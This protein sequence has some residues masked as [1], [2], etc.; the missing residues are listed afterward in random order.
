MVEFIVDLLSQGGIVYTPR[1]N[2]LPQLWTEL[3]IDAVDD[4]WGR[5]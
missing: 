4:L 5:G 3:H 2:P 1:V